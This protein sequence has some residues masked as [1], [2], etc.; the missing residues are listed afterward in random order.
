MAGKKKSVT[1]VAI[2][3]DMT[4]Y[5]AARHK[6]TLVDALTQCDLVEVD[7]SGVSEIDSA[8]FQLLVMAKQEA[9]RLNKQLVIVSHSAPVSELLDFLGM[10]ARFGDPVLVASTDR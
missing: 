6:T 7:L 5:N 10:V 9:A 4:I 3:D 8:G 2:V 1:R